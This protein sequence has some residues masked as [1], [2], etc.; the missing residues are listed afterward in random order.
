VIHFAD[1]TKKW[2]SV[3]S[4][5][6]V[7]PSLGPTFAADFGRTP[8]SAGASVTKLPSLC[9]M[10]VFPLSCLKH[11]LRSK[12]FEDEEQSKVTPHSNL[13]RCTK[14]T[15][16][17]ASSSGRASGISLSKQNGSGSEGIST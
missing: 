7:H 14:Q 11:N 13:Y 12:A 4:Q 3:E 16:G 1:M 15:T 2:R 10:R 5:I 6:T 17:G 8:H 9:S